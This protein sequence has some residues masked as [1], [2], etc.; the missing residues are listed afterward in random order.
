MIKYPI[1]PIN[2]RPIPT[3]WAILTNS[4]HEV[5]VINY[6]VKESTTLVWLGAALQKL[7]AVLCEFARH[8]EE[9]GKVVRHEANDTRR[10]EVREERSCRYH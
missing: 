8:L 2:T 1:K 4:K 5:F 10:E 3:A 7:L 6:T 9:T